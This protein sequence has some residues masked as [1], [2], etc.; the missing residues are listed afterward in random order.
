MKAFLFPIQLI[1][2]TMFIISGCNKGDNFSIEQLDGRPILAAHRCNATLKL[3]EATLE[4]I[5]NYEVDIHI[6]YKD[7][8]PFLMI[9][10]ELESSTGQSLT[11]YIGYL[12]EKNPNFK[13]LWMDFKDLDSDDNEKDALKILARLD[14]MYNIKKRVLIEGQN[15]QF[16]TRFTEEGWRTSYYIPWQEF[17]NNSDTHQKEVAEKIMDEMSIYNISGI[18]YDATVHQTIEKYFLNEKI[19]NKKIRLHTWDLSITFGDPKFSHKIS[20]YSN[21]CV[22]LFTFPSNNNI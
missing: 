19:N 9:G 7:G 14:R 4:G 18:S 1:L 20:K 22:T 10:H 17:E 15:P 8:D 3:D 5:N 6:E 2:A 11:D 16:L 21:T 13:F 12:V